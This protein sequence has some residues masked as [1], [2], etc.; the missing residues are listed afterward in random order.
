MIDFVW[1]MI[2][3]SFKYIFVIKTKMGFDFTKHLTN[4]RKCT[5]L[6]PSSCINSLWFFVLKYFYDYFCVLLSVLI[7]YT[8]VFFFALSSWLTL[9][10]EKLSRI[11]RN[12]SNVNNL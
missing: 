4:V 11:R 2:F 5:I 8:N 10:N 3:T 9:L 12:E 7:T 1:F 6:R